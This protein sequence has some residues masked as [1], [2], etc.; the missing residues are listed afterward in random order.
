MIFNYWKKFD[1]LGSVIKTLWLVIFILVFINIIMFIGWK[2]APQKLRI[3]LP[4]DLSQGA[5]IKPN[6]IPKSTIYAFAYQ[7]FT[8]INTWSNNGEKDY[9]ENINS[10]K[11]YLSA[12]F[13]SDLL[14]DYSKR[15]SEGALGRKRIMAGVSSMG[16]DPKDVKVLGNGAWIVDIKLQITETI[17]ASVVKSV[18]M[19]YPIIIAKINESIQVNPWGLI[20]KGYYK[21]PYRIKTI[22]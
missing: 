10:Y 22:I 2:S 12:E 3:Y 4:P 21:E 5:M 18:F 11:N 7:I 19:D 9:K 8:A 6:E 20:I 17:G 13:K 15:E 14:I 1:Q 16:Y